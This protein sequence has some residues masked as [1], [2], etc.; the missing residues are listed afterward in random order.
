MLA[1]NL[2]ATCIRLAL[3]VFVTLLL[4][5]ADVTINL[6]LW[7]RFSERT[8]LATKRIRFSD[9]LKRELY[10]EQ[11]GRCLYCG[12][13]KKIKAYEIDH[14][15]P[16]ARGGSNDKHNLQLLC[17]A[18]N[19]RK[20]VQSDVEFRERY[21]ELL[22]TRGNFKPPQKVI[23]QQA[24]VRVMKQTEIASSVRRFK[25]GKHV[26][27]KSKLI[28]G[29]GIVGLICGLVWAWQLPTLVPS[30]FLLHPIYGYAYG[31]GTIVICMTVWIGLL[32]RSKI[33]G[34]YDQ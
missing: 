1:F 18:C 11:N 33:T 10:Q 13:A 2:I 32:L 5:V 23:P 20:G 8:V 15:H 9:D 19:R 25:A 29:T 12:V 27:A 6:I 7:A 34:A 3:R 22:S 17:R 30:E 4:F 21:S 28:P 14:K 26:T 31:Y 24:F 16:A